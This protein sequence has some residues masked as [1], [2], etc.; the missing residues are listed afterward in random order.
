MCTVHNNTQYKMLC[1][2]WPDK[3]MY[4]ISMQLAPLAKKFIR[5]YAH[6]RVSNQNSIKSLTE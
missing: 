6:V 5:A 1:I 3:E 4:A 2:E